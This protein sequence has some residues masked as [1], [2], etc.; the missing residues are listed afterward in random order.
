MWSETNEIVK[1]TLINN[2]NGSRNWFPTFE[3]CAVFISRELWRLRNKVL[4]VYKSLGHGPRK[5][6]S[7][8][9]TVGLE[10]WR[11]CIHVIAASDAQMGIPMIL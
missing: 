8:R 1:V 4:F 9:S 5:K 7:K 11:P 3:G 2:E 10:L 6:T